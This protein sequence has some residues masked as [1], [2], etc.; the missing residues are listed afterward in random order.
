MEAHNTADGK[1][2]SLDVIAEGPVAE[3]FTPD[4]LQKTYGGR[5]AQATGAVRLNALA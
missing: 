1:L 2:D 3:V 5:L 4:M